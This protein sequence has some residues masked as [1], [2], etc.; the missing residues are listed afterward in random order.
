M[1]KK[2]TAILP[3]TDPKDKDFEYFIAAH[4]Q[5][6]GLYVERN[7]VDRDEVEYL[8]L[9]IITS[10]YNPDSIKRHLVEI[11]SGKFH[12]NEVFKIK[13][14]MEYLKESNGIFVTKQT[15]DKFELYKN[16]ATCINIDLI[17]NSNLKKTIEN[18]SKYFIR[19][20]DEMVIQ[21]ILYSFMMENKMNQMIKHFK[22]SQRNKR[23]YE[24][25]DKYFH[26]INSAS[27]FIREPN[28][29]TQE[30]F[31]H[32]TKNKNLT[33]KIAEELSNTRWRSL[34]PRLSRESYRSIFYDCTNTSLQVSLYVEHMARL[35]LI[36]TCV[37]YMITCS[38]RN[39]SAII[40]WLEMSDLPKNIQNAVIEIRREPYFHCYPVFWQ[41]FTH[42]MGGFILLDKLDLEYAYISKQVG[43]PIEYIDQAFSSYDKLFPVRDS[44]MKKPTNSSIRVLSFFPPLFQ[45]IGA[46]HR[47]SMYLNMKEESPISLLSEQLSKDKT[48]SDLIKWNN[49]AYAV[50]SGEIGE[51]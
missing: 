14:W 11:K 26:F 1:T 28:E 9:D 18:L 51:Y 16:K 36:K 27:F 21:S 8:E 46:N 38:N 10:N 41:F 12:F 13:G 31:K 22:S 45:G 19:V 17:D 3:P 37:E 47:R 34:D 6:S 5:A 33:A 50:L 24:N 40:R 49:L 25:L 48:M 43:I 4:M 35:T 29:R 20:P 32:W 42:V 15:P 7:I 23:C 2:T 39:E 30:L 44:W